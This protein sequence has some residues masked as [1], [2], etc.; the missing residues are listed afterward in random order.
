MPGLADTL[1]RATAPRAVVAISRLQ[2]PRR[3][4]AAIR[5]ARGQRACIE[6]FFAYD[7]PYS[8]IALPGLMAIA[9]QRNAELQIYPLIE[10]GIAGDPAAAQR[11]KHALVDSRRLALRTGR[12]FSREQPLA[13]DDCAFLAAWTE[14]A[15]GHAGMAAFAA[16]ALEQLWCNSNNVPAPEDFQN[17]YR[18][19]IGLQAPERTPAITAALSRNTARLQRL[20]HLES[21]TARFDRQ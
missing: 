13:A 3:L 7:D 18:Q 15:R 14:A 9:R 2:W 11:R 1:R 17:L 19:R 5:R 4:R 6:L 8:A 21:P 16:A 10:R 20:G 12:K